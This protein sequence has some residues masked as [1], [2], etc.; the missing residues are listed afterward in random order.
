MSYYQDLSYCY[1]SNDESFSYVSH[2]CYCPV[3]NSPPVSM[4]TLHQPSPYNNNNNN[5]NIN[6]QPEVSNSINTNS[7]SLQVCRE[8]TR[9]FSSEQIRILEEHFCKI[10][11]YLSKLTIDAVST[12]TQL[13]PTQIRVWFNN[14]RTR[15]RHE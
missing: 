12:R 2:P 11:K 4:C 6:T 3:H 8:K 14:K 15:E 10:D 5:G 7:S 9:R 1:S 13:K